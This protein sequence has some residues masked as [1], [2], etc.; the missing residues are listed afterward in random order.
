M[1]M[2]GYNVAALAVALLYYIWRTYHQARLLRQRVLRERV[3]FMLWS[4]AERMDAPGR[5]VPVFSRG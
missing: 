1:E 5:T 2:V 3:A 4:A